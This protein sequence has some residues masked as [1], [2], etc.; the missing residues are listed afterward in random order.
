MGFRPASQKDSQMLLR[1]FTA[2]SLSVNHVY[3]TE[4]LGKELGKEHYAKGLLIRTSLMF[5]F[6]GTNVKPSQENQCL[7]LI[8]QLLIG[9]PMVC[10]YLIAQ[11][12]LTTLCVIWKV[13]DTR[14]E[15][16]YDKGFLG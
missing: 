7:W 4:T 9:D 2:F 6:I 10:G 11:M 1:L 16:H 3:T 12:I 5:L 8:I 14:M 13:T 15:H